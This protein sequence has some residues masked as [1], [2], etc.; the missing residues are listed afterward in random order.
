MENIMKCVTILPGFSSRE[1]VGKTVRVSD[2]LASLLVFNG[3]ATYAPKSL[4]K[5]QDR[6]VWRD[7]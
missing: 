7:V 3:D 2:D 4:W 1:D 6:V 5:S